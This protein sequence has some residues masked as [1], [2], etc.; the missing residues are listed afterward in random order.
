MAPLFYDSFDH[1]GTAALLAEKWGLHS[2]GTSTAAIAIGAYGRNS[3]QG[4][5]ISKAGAGDGAWV[6]RAVNNLATTVQGFALKGTG[7]DLMLVQFMDGS[8]V[9]CAV[10]LRSDGRLEAYDGAGSIIGTGSAIIGSS[11]QKYVEIQP[12]IHA[13]TGGIVVKVDGTTDI[14]TGGNDD[15]QATANAYMTAVRVGEHSSTS[16]TYNYDIDDFYLVDTT[17]GALDDFLGDV[18]VE[19]LMPTGAGNYTDF[20]P[21]AGSNYENVDETAP[22][23]DTTYN[24]SATVDDRDTYALGNLAT[25]SGTVLA[26]AVTS[27]TRKEDA[28]ARTLR[29]VLWLTSATTKDQESAAFSPSTAYGFN[30]SIFTA[31]GDAAAFDITKVNALEAGVTIE[32]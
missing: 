32:A 5:R 18:R 9:Q 2:A 1:Y 28:G 21:S 14:D 4:L 17:G 23:D 10:G 22:D 12:T 8:T 29:N 31:D 20:T 27:R 16:A 7:A 13:S 15:T 3:T 11:V 26:V 6:Q 25:V 19:C 30:Q 24:H